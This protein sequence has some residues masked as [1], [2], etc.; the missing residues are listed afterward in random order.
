MTTIDPNAVD[1]HLAQGLRERA[2]D[3]GDEDQFYEQVLATVAVVPQRRWFRRWPARFGRRTSL[4][5]IAA[6]LLS[7]LGSSGWRRVLP[8]F[9]P[10]PSGPA[11]GLERY[12]HDDRRPRVAHRHASGRWHGARG[13]RRDRRRRSG[14]APSSTT[15]PAGHGP[16]HGNMSAGRHLHTATLLRRWQGARR[17]AVSAWMRRGRLSR[18]IRP[19]APGRGL[20]PRA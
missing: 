11:R 16:R 17:P 4:V 12:R 6:A 18:P 20:P 15:P 8:A 1:T 14:P 7:L 10:R 19:Q 3:L 13:G 2:A 9:A 5:L